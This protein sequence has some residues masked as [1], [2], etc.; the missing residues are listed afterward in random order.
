MRGEATSS[1]STAKVMLQDQISLEHC[2]Q[3]RQA[4][5]K[6]PRVR[7]C[8]GFVLVFGVQALASQRRPLPA[9]R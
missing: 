3:Q 6:P 5:T 9:I 7:V 4:R 2:S 8:L 1:R